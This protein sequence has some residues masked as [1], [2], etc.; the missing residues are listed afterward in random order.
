MRL[1]LALLCSAVALAQPAKRSDHLVRANQ[2]GFSDSR[3]QQKVGDSYAGHLVVRK[4]PAYEAG[5][6]YWYFRAEENPDTAPLVVWIQGGPGGS[7]VEDGLFF[8]MGPL[9]V[10]EKEGL[11]PE[12]PR[13]ILR[14]NPYTWTRKYNMIFLDQPVGTGFS[15]VDPPTPMIMSDKLHNFWT[16]HLLNGRTR[17]QPLSAAQ[18]SKLNATFQFTDQTQPSSSAPTEDGDFAHGYAANEA[19]VSKDFITFMLAFYDLFPETKNLSLHLTSESYGGKYVPEIAAAIAK[20]NDDASSAAQ[21]IPL[22][23]L[24]I[25]NQWTDPHTQIGVHP[26]H[27]LQIGL[28][29]DVQAGLLSEPIERARDAV[30][31]EDWVG[32]L[33]ARGDMFQML[34]V[35]TGGINWYDFRLGNKGLPVQH[36]ERYLLQEQTQKTLHAQKKTFGTD[37]AVFMSLA[38]DNMKTT[39]PLFPDLLKRYKV[40]LY[41]GHFDLRDGVVSNS[42]WIEAIDWDGR[43]PFKFANR[44]VW[45]SS[46]GELQGYVTQYANLT[47]VVLLGCG[48]L[49][50]ADDGCPAASLEMITRHIDNAKFL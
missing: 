33:E 14:R 43:V 36:I 25:G 30:K 41:Q 12:R 11:S 21:K 42:R 40:L 47:R 22:T 24:A 13:Y 9:R 35:F 15:Y 46:E 16:R 49:A 39:L 6:F 32:G 26:E 44:Q 48:H 27:F 17:V 8:E 4:T 18:S 50:P 34:S 23:T 28:I 45:T 19:G 10:E 20:H 2:L 5:V 3:D 31:R 7:S 29:D 37:S 38:T 1:A